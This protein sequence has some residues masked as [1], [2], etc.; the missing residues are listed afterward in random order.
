MNT[1]D[2]QGEGASALGGYDLCRDQV[3]SRNYP[4][5]GAPVAIN[6]RDMME[7]K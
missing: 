4:R 1:T 5:G 6:M 3:A 2:P 7:Q